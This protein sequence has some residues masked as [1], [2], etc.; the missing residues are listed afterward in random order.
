MRIIYNWW[1]LISL[2]QGTAKLKNRGLS[3]AGWLCKRPGYTKI[4]S[5]IHAMARYDMANVAYSRIGSRL[6]VCI[7]LMPL[8]KP[9]QAHT[10]HD[11]QAPYIYPV[12]IG[13]IIT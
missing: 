2:K 1:A 11:G 4:M 5:T 12:R 7:D 8:L 9:V 10:G 3:A 6:V 13:W